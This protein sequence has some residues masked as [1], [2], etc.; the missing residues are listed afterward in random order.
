[1]PPRPLSPRPMSPS[2]TATGASSS[3]RSRRR[4]PTTGQSGHHTQHVRSANGRHLLNPPRANAPF[5]RRA[6][7][8][9]PSTC[10][11]SRA[12]PEETTTRVE[13]RPRRGLDGET[14][15]GLDRPPPRRDQHHAALA[16][17]RRQPAR[18]A[19][20]YVWWRCREHEAHAV[21]QR[22]DHRRPA[23][24]GTRRTTANRSSTTS[25]SATAKPPRVPSRSTA[26]AHSPAAVAA[27]ASCNVTDVTPA[28]CAPST[29]TVAPRCTAAPG[30]NSPSGPVTGNTRSRANTTGR[31]ARAAVPRSSRASRSRRGSAVTVT[32]LPYRTYV[33]SVKSAPAPQGSVFGRFRTGPRSLKENL[34]IR[35]PV[36]W[37]C[38]GSERGG[39]DSY[40]VGS[41]GIT[42][43]TPMARRFSG[44]QPA[45][46]P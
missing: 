12:L 11:A 33:R 31:T 22:G 1:M 6:T 18:V 14:H 19:G 41:G 29:T 4:R 30:N 26:A 44:D 32:R 39:W 40:A 21:E 16:G 24:G 43:S 17:A 25:C 9:R 28:P 13:L 7:T 45:S 15:C 20:P 34:S 23:G 35:G 27:R 42:G 3:D 8:P 36:R 10:T 38:S 46:S 5:W 2:S 37:N